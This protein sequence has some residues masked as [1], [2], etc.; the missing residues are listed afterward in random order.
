MY[1]TI[2]D[3]DGMMCEMCE[4]HINDSI[5]NAM[6]VKKVNS[7]YRNNKTEILTVESPDLEIIKS[8]IEHTGYK[9]VKIQS[10]AYQKKG[11]F[12]F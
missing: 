11:L 1:Q 2:V 12:H 9:V 5:R 7:S 10:Q 6:K 3:V 4:S 8:A